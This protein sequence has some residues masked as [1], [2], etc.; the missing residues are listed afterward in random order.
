[1]KQGMGSKKSK[2][3]ESGQDLLTS[4]GNTAHRSNQSNKRH[5]SS[6][7]SCVQT[8]P[9]KMYTSMNLIEQGAQTEPVLIRPLL[10]QKVYNSLNIGNGDVDDISIFSDVTS[11]SADVSFSSEVQLSNQVKG[12][13][14]PCTMSPDSG[15]F[16]SNTY[17]EDTQRTKDT[18]FEGAEAPVPTK[19]HRRV[20]E[21]QEALPNLD[22][23]NFECS[24]WV[25][26]EEVARIFATSK[27]RR[28]EAIA[29]AC[30]C[31]FLLTDTLRVNKN[32]GSQ[33][34]VYIFSNALA[35]LEK[36]RSILDEKF[37]TFYVKSS[38]VVHRQAPA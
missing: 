14:D 26:A 20:P 37:P 6:T 28:I 15:C 27:D 30:N 2:P 11:L 16:T 5:A 3:V 10:P 1:M 34:L 35:D 23:A 25:P 4:R 22:A 12:N 38:E 36:C 21:S 29:R 18:V 7:E 17:S 33:K 31:Q 8:G 9:V 24:M 19:R 13:V 32:L